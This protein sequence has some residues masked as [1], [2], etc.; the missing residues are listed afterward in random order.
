M[1]ETERQ[2]HRLRQK[3]GE[4]RE[5]EAKRKWNKKRRAERK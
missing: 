3:E 1:T 5:T 4:K 2:G